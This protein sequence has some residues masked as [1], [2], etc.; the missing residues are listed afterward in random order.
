MSPTRGEECRTSPLGN[1]DKIL[2]GGA[3]AANKNGEGVKP[4]GVFAEAFRKAYL[5]KYELFLKKAALRRQL[6]E[7]VEARALLGCCISRCAARVSAYPIILGS[8]TYRVSITSI[9]TFP[10]YKY[11]P[12]TIYPV[13][14]TS[15]KRY[16]R[17]RDY[18]R[19]PRDKV[20]YVCTIEPSGFR[21]VAD[22]GHVWE[23]PGCWERFV[24]S[25][26][27]SSEYGSFEEFTGLAHSSVTRMIEK[28]G[29]VSKFDGYIPLDRRT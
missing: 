2:C 22:D 18:K 3:A 13:G 12:T 14:F 8:S 4:M 28:I 6:A 17:H 16:R 15:K 23:G 25:V 9:G 20:L 19:A 29:D 5:R 26:G 21:I 1:S 24:E 11:T 7:V 10:P 27:G